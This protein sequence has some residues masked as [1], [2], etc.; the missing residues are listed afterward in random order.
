MGYLFTIK[1][2]SN[3]EE[4]R[5]Y[6]E[7]LKVNEKYDEFEWCENEDGYVS[8]FE[9]E[10]DISRISE[11]FPTTL[12]TVYQEHESVSLS[13]YYDGRIYDDFTLTVQYFKYGKFTKEKHVKIILK[14]DEFN[15]LDE[16]MLLS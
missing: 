4:I 13:D 8:W 16:K 10:R 1:F 15:E 9:Y 12:I 3:E 2:D 11:K 6:I 7:I 5:E 14:F